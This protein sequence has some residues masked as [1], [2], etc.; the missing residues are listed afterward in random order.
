M[1]ELNSSGILSA[2][3]GGAA[4]VPPPSAVLAVAAV[5]A[6]PCPPPSSEDRYRFYQCV[7]E[8]LHIT[9]KPIAPA[10]IYT[11]IPGK[12]TQIQKIASWVPSVADRS[13]IRWRFFTKRS[14]EFETE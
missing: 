11:E 2:A 3:V 5:A 4:C 9:C 12:N 1:S 6:A 13:I 7:F 10:D 14:L 8:P